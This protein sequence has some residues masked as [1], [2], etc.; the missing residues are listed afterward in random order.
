[1]LVLDQAAVGRLL[2]IGAC[3]EVMTATL[4]ALARGDAVLPLRTVIRIPDTSNAF[5]VMPAYVDD[6]A[7]VIGAKVITVYPGNHATAFD[8]HQ[9]AVLLFDSATGA[10]AALVDATA[11]TTVRTAAVSAVATRLLAR[12][13]ASRLA[14]LGAGVQGQAHLFAMCASRS[15]TSV[16]IWSRD[17]ARANRLANTAERALGIRASVAATG[18]DA[19]RGADVVCTTTS[20]TTPVLL[21]DW[22]EP[23]TH[24]NAIG[25]CTPNARELD[26]AAVVRSRLYVDRRESALREPGDILAPLEAGEITASHVIAELGDVLLGSSAGRR[27]PEE[28]TLFKSLGLAIEDLAAASFVYAEAQRTGDGISVSLGGRRDEAH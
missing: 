20:A 14:I 9:G 1:M 28:I 18:A 26:S 17:S 10:L 13:D 22:I 25:A 6:V 8:A 27:S 12:E 23:G 4:T 2:P 16:R 21:G 11:I 7:P 5:A 3:I 24:V 15:I 19:V